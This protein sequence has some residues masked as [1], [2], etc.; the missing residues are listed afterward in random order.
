MQIIGSLGAGIQ[1]GNR[2]PGS[3][4]EAARVGDGDAEH[5]FP[6]ARDPDPLADV[7]RERSVTRTIVSHE[8]SGPATASCFAAAGP[9]RLQP[10]VTEQARSIAAAL[11]A[12]GR[13]GTS[14]D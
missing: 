8:T 9:E 5:G 13:T 10:N 7:I 1:Q 4:K 6:A 14:P 3:R 2:A 11:T 12:A